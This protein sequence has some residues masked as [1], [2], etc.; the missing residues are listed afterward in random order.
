VGSLRHVL[1]IGGPP[2]SG[3]TTVATRLMRRHGLRWYNADTRTWAH[4]DRAVREMV[5]AAIRW[6]SDRWE[7]ASADELLARSLHYERGPMVVDDVRG[8][9]ASPLVVAE[10]STVPPDVVSSGVADPA[11]ALWLVPTEAFQQARLDE[12]DV[13]PPARVLYLR[14]AGAIERDVAEHGAP[15]LQVDDSIG[16]EGLVNA[17]EEV[18]RDALAQGP[19]AESVAE[20]RAL[21]REANDRIVAQ[22]RG[23]HTRPWGTGDPE[24]VVREFVCE[25]GDRGCTASLEVTVRQVAAGPVVAA[26]H[27]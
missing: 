1:W 26:G 6:E 27:V 9:P 4:R 25:C 16:V 2:G 3:K 20:R 21:L 18:F 12:R 17:V 23:F 8:L 24:S 5:P 22:V 11:R 15:V 14:M 10:G 7:G 13:P 19:C